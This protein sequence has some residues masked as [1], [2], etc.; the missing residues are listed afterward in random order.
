MFHLVSLSLRNFPGRTPLPGALV[1]V[2][3]LVVGFSF[4][5]LLVSSREIFHFLDL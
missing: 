1:G 5:F 4:V 2:W 3:V